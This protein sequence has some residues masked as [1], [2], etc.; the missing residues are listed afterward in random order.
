MSV[1]WPPNSEFVG[2]LTRTVRRVILQGE[3]VFY[4]YGKCLRYIVAI[5]NSA[6]AG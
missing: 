2:S 6:I 4:S 5:G 1:S 3:T